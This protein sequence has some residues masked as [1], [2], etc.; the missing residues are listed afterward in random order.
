[1]W[2]AFPS[3]VVIV[4]DTWMASEIESP[5]RGSQSLFLTTMHKAPA[6][7]AV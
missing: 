4:G 1:M 7:A 3:G 6:R 2:E 5:A